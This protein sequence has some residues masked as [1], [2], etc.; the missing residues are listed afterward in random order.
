MSIRVPVDHS[1]DAMPVPQTR[2]GLLLQIVSTEKLAAVYR[3]VFQEMTVSWIRALSGFRFREA[4]S[5]AR[6]TAAWGRDL[7]RV[8]RRLKL[9]RDHLAALG[10]PDGPS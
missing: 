5:R 9:L 8:E 4:A 2:D 1:V 6:T 7:F 3:A 10:G